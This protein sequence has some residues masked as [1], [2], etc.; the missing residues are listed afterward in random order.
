MKNKVKR[1]GLRL[2]TGTLTVEPECL[3]RNKMPAATEDQAL[4]ASRPSSGV[5]AGHRISRTL[6]RP[7]KTPTPPPPALLPG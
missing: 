5:W 1:I 2:E 4:G 7:N 6:K 3:M